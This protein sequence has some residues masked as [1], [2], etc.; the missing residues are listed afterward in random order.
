MTQHLSKRFCRA[1]T[2]AHSQAVLV[3]LVLIIP[4]PAFSQVR[5]S[6]DVVNRKTLA[7]DTIDCERVALGDPDDYKPD[8]IMLPNGE[9]ILVAF[10]QHK[11]EDGR[12]L[13]QNL[14]FRSKDGGKTWSKPEKLGL[15]GREPYLTVLKDGT[16]FMTGHLLANDVR[17]KYGY[18][19]GYLHRSTDAG[20]TWE[21]IRIESEG[22]RPKASNHS[23]RNVLEIADGT[24]L[25]GVDYDGGSG[26][27][28]MWR[29]RDG[30][31]TWDKAQKCEP[32]DFQSK[33]GFFGGETWLWQ[34][35]SGKIW[36]LVRVDSNELPIKNRPIKAGNDQSDHFILFSSADRGR[37]FD[38]I[39]D[40]GDYGEMYMSISNSTLLTTE[41][42]LTPRRQS[43]FREAALAPR[44]NSRT[45]H[46]SPR[47][48]TV[49]RTT[50]RTSKS[51][52]GS[53]RRDGKPAGD[54]LL[55]KEI[56]RGLRR[57]SLAFCSTSS[58]RDVHRADHRQTG[59]ME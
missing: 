57:T 10:H 15:L 20:K 41:S 32:K 27:Y 14:M 16:L 58:G 35:R 26:P 43:A 45:G 50:S 30:G 39:R 28:L 8:L 5:D 54:V 55:V 1:S 47:I 52:A 7:A 17:N 42:C 3:V 49:A 48:R 53:C 23:T 11:K 24:L 31:K 38:R 25:L 44:F 21:S 22:I 12:V 56:D 29:S 4:T 46:W 59:S 37:S 40:F 51:C 34:A 2:L 6:I 18:I 19:H 9:L 33:Y 36:A 13:E